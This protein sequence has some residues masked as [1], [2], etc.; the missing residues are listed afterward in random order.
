MKFLCLSGNHDTLRLVKHN[1]A[2]YSPLRMVSLLSTA[3]HLTEGSKEIQRRAP[4]GLLR[5]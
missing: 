3:E 4:S 1:A 5:L 2:S